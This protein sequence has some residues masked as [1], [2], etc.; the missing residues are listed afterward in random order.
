MEIL[1]DRSRQ[2]KGTFF[3][4]LPT[5]PAPSTRHGDPLRPDTPTRLRP[6]PHHALKL[7][8][9]L[10]QSCGKTSDRPA[11]PNWPKP[12]RFTWSVRGSATAGRGQLTCYRCRATLMG[13]GLVSQPAQSR[14]P[15]VPKG[16]IMLPGQRMARLVPKSRWPKLAG[17]F[18][19][20]ALAAHQLSAADQPRMKAA[21][22]GEAGLLGPAEVSEVWT[23]GEVVLRFLKPGDGAERVLLKGADTTF[24]ADGYRF[25]LIGLGR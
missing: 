19:S 16:A 21:I 2:I 23:T 4:R 1:G 14:K 17:V 25:C 12:S 3:C 11:K 18:L 22:G 20:L 10:G 13:V 24:V 15:E 8:W 6:T 9:S 7:G 5:P